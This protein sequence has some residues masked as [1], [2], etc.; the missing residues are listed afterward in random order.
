MSKEAQ[1]YHLKNSVVFQLQTARDGLKQARAGVRTASEALKALQEAIS[2][3]KTAKKIATGQDSVRPLPQAIMKKLDK[4][5]E[6]LDKTVE[7]VKAVPVT[8]DQRDQKALERY[9]KKKEA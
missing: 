4:A 7:G 8:K 6:F 3:A 9:R 1:R 2:K 5:I